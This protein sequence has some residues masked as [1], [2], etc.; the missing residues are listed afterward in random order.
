M[1]RPDF[2]RPT[3]PPIAHVLQDDNAYVVDGDVVEAKA[4]Q[5]PSLPL[6]CRWRVPL[7]RVHNSSDVLLLHRDQLDVQTFDKVMVYVNVDGSVT[8]RPERVYG[9]CNRRVAFVHQKIV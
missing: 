5:K 4:E 3:T 9:T 1:G 6:G 8:P 2:G 7:T